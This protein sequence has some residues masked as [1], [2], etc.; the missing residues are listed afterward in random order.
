[1]Y[2]SFSNFFLQNFIEFL[3]NFSSFF[4]SLLKFFRINSNLSR[5]FSKTPTE[6]LQNYFKMSQ[7]FFQNF[8]NI[9]PQF[10]KKT[11]IYARFSWVFSQL[12]YCSHSEHFSNTFLKPFSELFQIFSKFHQI[13]VQ[14]LHTCSFQKVNLT[15][16]HNF[17]VKYSY[18]FCSFSKVASNFSRRFIKFPSKYF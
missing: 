3:R 11:T 7:E 1:M 8:W 4:T 6:L 18:I 10:P 9:I 13:S 16:H 14:F 2:Q 17:S 12:I 15:F 5:N